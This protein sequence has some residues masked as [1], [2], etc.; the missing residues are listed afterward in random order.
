MTYKEFFILRVYYFD[1]TYA[2]SATYF[3]HVLE[4]F[5]LFCVYHS[6]NLICSS[7]NQNVIICY[8][9]PQIFEL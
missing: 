3:H 4:L 8:S 9:C 1:M 6:P 5:Q 7:Y 2:F